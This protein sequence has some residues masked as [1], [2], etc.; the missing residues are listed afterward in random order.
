MG[1]PLIDNYWCVEKISKGAFGEVWKAI[2]QGD[3]NNIIGNNK[4]N[5][6]AIK[7]EKKE[8]KSQLRNEYTILSYITS[9]VCITPH[10]FHFGETPTFNYMVI[11][12]LG[13]S[14]DNYYRDTCNNISKTAETPLSILKY[15]GRQMLNCIQSV[16]KCGIIHRDIKP[17]NFLLSAD[18]KKIYIIDFGISTLYIDNKKHHKPMTHQ[19]SRLG[20][21]DFISYY[22]HEGLSASRRDDLISMIY[23]IIYLYN[24]IL[25]W[26]KKGVKSKY[27]LKY[28]ISPKMLCKGLP[29]KINIM[30]VYCYGLEYTTEPNYEYIRFLFETM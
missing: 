17:Q 23:V 6:V 4:H 11:E 21:I 12:L 27:E 28:N 18:N 15:I 1:L 30:L 10:V 29:E 22:L 14:I 25:P 20:T 19:N 9:T 7:I 5:E 2:R 13:K 3:C 16:H 24:N 26:Q 8:K